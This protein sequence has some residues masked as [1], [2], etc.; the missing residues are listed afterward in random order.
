MRRFLSPWCAVA[1]LLA[2][3]AVLMAGPVREESA[4]MDEPVVL[5]A[6]YLWCSG[7]GSRF[8]PEHPPLGQMLPALPLLFLDVNVPEFLQQ[9][10]QLR[11]GVPHARP[12]KGWEVGRAE[13]YY[14]GGRSSWY[15]WP[16]WEAGIFGQE[17]LYGGWNDPDLLL[18][19]SRAM[20][21]GLTV[22]TGVLIVLWL[23]RLAGME[24]ALMGLA[25][26]VF[27]PVALAYGHLVVTDISV[28]FGMT[29]AIW[30]FALM[31]D[32]PSWKTALCAGIATGVALAMK[33]SAVLLAPVYVVLIVAFFWCNRRQWGGVN[34]FGKWL[35]LVAVSAWA[36]VLVVYAPHWKP[37][38]ALS[39][40]DAARI[41]VPGWFQALRPVLVPADFFKGI[42]LQVAHAAYGHEA[43]LCGEWRLKGWWYYFPLALLWKLPIPLLALTLTGGLMWLARVRRW[44]FAET[45]PWLSALAY[46]GLAM[47]STINIGV[48]YLLPMM[49]LLSV[50][51]AQQLTRQS[52]RWRVAAWGLCGWLAAI[53]LWAY[54]Y[55]IEYFNELAGGPRYGYRRLVDSNYDWGQDGKR[56]RAWWW[57]RGCPKIL[58]RFFG[59][60]KAIQYYGITAEGATPEKVQ[61]ARQGTL[62]ISASV[63]MRPEWRWLEQ[64][65]SPRERIGHALFVYDLGDAK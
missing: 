32:E 15:Y 6:G 5:A 17:L 65:R 51:V 28:T 61:Q 37:A 58:L 64:Q 21:V 41:G 56:L 19:V 13:Q 44:E 10:A 48:R 39:A 1:T 3:M 38:P 25:T 20:Q 29:W 35:P 16:Y 9:L 62:V 42:A 43:F 53:V 54:P 14:S 40:E 2:L 24:A 60:G 26:W 7:Y 12:W 57:Q 50:G 11:L 22:L 34:R 23:Q 36:V 59:W 52:R 63:L 31:L 49:P 18:W 27:N 30:A 4:T 33:F 46:L 55:Y 8:N 45:V 47:T